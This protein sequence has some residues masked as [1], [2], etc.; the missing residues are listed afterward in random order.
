M[1]TV[2]PP[3]ARQ[4]GCAVVW[5]GVLLSWAVLAFAEAMQSVVGGGVAIR[6]S[7]KCIMLLSSSSAGL[8]CFC[9]FC[10]AVAY[11]VTE[12]P[13]W[14]TFALALLWFVVLFP[15]LLPSHAPPRFEYR[16]EATKENQ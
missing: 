8:L 11:S 9:Y 6:R 2:V 12:Q 5:A 3:D 13:F 16:T 7:A 4:T 14:V 1:A 10:S 15:T